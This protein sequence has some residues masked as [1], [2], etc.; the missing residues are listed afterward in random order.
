M[1]TREEAPKPLQLI[2]TAYAELTAEPGGLVLDGMAIAGLPDRPVP[3]AEVNRLLHTRGTTDAVKDAAWAHLVEASREH[4]APWTTVCAGLA[5]PGLRNAYRKAR[6]SAPEFID[7]ADLASAAIEAFIAALADIDLRYPRIAS[8]LCNR[9]YSGARAYARELT[10]YQEAMVSNEYES[11]PPKPQYGHIDLVLDKAVADGA[12]TEAQVELI[13]ATFIDGQEVK[14]YAAE[15]DLSPG[16]ITRRRREAKEA[17]AE[18]FSAQGFD[19]PIGMRELLEPTNRQ[20]GAG[21]TSALRQM[22]LT[23]R[24]CLHLRT[25]G[26]LQGPQWQCPR[27][28]R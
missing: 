24:T 16:T 14:D 6:W 13:W 2:R 28:H 21:N 10:A 15:L 18:W 11:H 7:R 3:V 12:I 25:P 27:H 1:R 23:K 22:S 17:I 26:L 9:A 4:A 20:K 8:R 5:L 19:F